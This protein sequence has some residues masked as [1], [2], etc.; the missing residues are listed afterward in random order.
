MLGAA[1]DPRSLHSP[2]I[3]LIGCKTLGQLLNAMDPAMHLSKRPHSLT[4]HTPLQVTLLPG[5]TC[6]STG[7]SPLLSAWPP[8]LTSQ[9]LLHATTHTLQGACPGRQGGGFCA[10]FQSSRPLSACLLC[11][12]TLPE[13]YGQLLVAWSAEL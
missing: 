8:Y 1:K 5:G 3:S 13:G 12:P 4:V 9:T 7:A 11:T 2:L 10:W 6:S